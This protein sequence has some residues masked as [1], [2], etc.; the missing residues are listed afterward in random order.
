MSV[1]VTL[2][3]NDQSFDDNKQNDFTTLLANPLY[4]D[5]GWEV[6][7][8]EISFN[9]YLL[10]NL[11]TVTIKNW[12]ETRCIKNQLYRFKPC[13]D[14]PAYQIPLMPNGITAKSLATFLSDIV[15]PLA[16][17]TDN[18]NR[19]IIAKE[20][21]SKYDRGVDAE[22]ALR[23]DIMNKYYSENIDAILNLNY[24]I[25]TTPEAQRSQTQ[26]NQLA[27][28]ELALDFFYEIPQGAQWNSPSNTPKEYFCLFR[29]RPTD[30]ARDERSLAE[31]SKLDKLFQF[32]KIP[33]IAD[34]DNFFIKIQ[35]KDFDAAAQALLARDQINVKIYGFYNLEQ[36]EYF[37]KFAQAKANEQAAEALGTPQYFLPSPLH[38]DGFKFTS[39]IFKFEPTSS[40]FTYNLQDDDSNLQIEIKGKLAA[41]LQNKDVLSH[42][43]NPSVA[44]STALSFPHTINAI[45]FIGIYSDCIT[46]QYVGN[47]FTRCLRIIPYNAVLEP[48]DLTNWDKS[49][50]HSEI[51]T[52]FENPVFVPVSKNIINS[53][54][55]ALKDMQGEP[56]KFSNL[57]SIVLVKLHFRRSENNYSDPLFSNH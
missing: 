11:G 33:C 32:Y 21:S 6:A 55:I 13:T 41:F 47:A 8:T 25:Y 36:K 31:D 28:N 44:E 17:Y 23:N 35:A 10:L 5:G 18:L 54:N 34:A 27:L 14:S 1:F 43:F 46:E 56:I 48:V 9:P 30:L 2:P 40:Q 19:Q 52:I 50:Q 29:K 39:P 45:P 26:T 57:Y 12:S 49:P 16:S 37:E 38:T 3:S 22:H 24:D 20:D 7:L 15:T 51:Y 4:L 42:L 53:I